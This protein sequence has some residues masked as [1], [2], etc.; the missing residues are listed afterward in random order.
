VS[1]LRPVSLFWTC[2]YGLFL[3]FTY[4]ERDLETLLR[5]ASIGS[6]FLEAAI[7]NLPPFP[8]PLFLTFVLN[9]CA[10]SLWAWGGSTHPGAHRPSIPS[11]FLRVTQG[12]PFWFSPA[13]FFFLLTL[14]HWSRTAFLLINR[15]FCPLCVV[16]P[17]A[18]IFFST[19]R[20]SIYF[21]SSRTILPS[22]SP[23]G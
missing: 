19:F 6:L 15:R 1:L 22:F 5:E 2:C 4:Q 11:F 23:T 10:S 20:G 18:P 14:D 17:A 12:K 13:L 21:P 8:Q 16:Q 3:S 7:I 9:A